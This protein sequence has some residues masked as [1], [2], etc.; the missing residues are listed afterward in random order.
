RWPLSSP[1]LD[2]HPSSL[3]TSS[4]H[5]PNHGLSKPCSS[6]FPPT[7]PRQP[8]PLAVNF[9]HR[10]LYP[11]RRPRLS[12]LPQ[13][14]HSAQHQRR[15]IGNASPGNVRRRSV[16]RF[17]QRRLLADVPAG[18]QTQPAHQPRAQVAHHVPV[19]VRHHHLLEL[20]RVHHQLHARVV[21][22]HFPVFDLAELDRHRT[23]A[24]Q[25]QPVRLFHNVRL[26][27]RGQLLPP[28][29]PRV[30][31]GEPRNPRRRLLRDDLQALHHPRHHFMLDAA[32]QVFGILPHDHQIHALE[33]CFHTRKVFHRPQVCIE[34]Q[35]LPQSHVDR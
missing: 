3:A 7:V 9:L 23:R 8:P 6:R 32:V 33:T 35:R 18:H 5:P 10:H 29:P 26:V 2:T 30:F 31:E 1:T 19:Q 15:G 14:H 13:H 4:L 16:H 34:V 25:K 12:H 28:L 24:A 27:H 17:K 20:S 21:H 22:N 11:L